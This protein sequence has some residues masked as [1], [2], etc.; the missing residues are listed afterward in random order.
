MS[1][2]QEIYRDILGWAL[3]GARNALS[4]FRT[5][6]PVRLMWPRQQR[7]LRQHYE[8][9]RFV[10]DIYFLILEE[11]F[12]LHDVSFLNFQARQFFERG[13]ERDCFN[14]L[15]APYIQELFA[16]V[17]EALRPQLSWPGPQGDY[18]RERWRDGLS[19]GGS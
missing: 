12:T 7:A 16:L 3:P 19:S 8:M 4:H 2:K 10:H 13:D 1:R 11:E 14:R 5:F 17:P 6:R 15:L 18:S 9:A